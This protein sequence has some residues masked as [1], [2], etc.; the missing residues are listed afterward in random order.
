MRGQSELFILIDKG[1][2]CGPFPFYIDIGLVLISVNREHSPKSK[3][4]NQ[5]FI[6][7][8]ILFTNIDIQQQKANYPPRDSSKSFE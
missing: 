2:K 5:C 1:K 4:E 7:K 3:T 6:K 8:M